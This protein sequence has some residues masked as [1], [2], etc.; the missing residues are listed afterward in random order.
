MKNNYKS[1]K[2]IR[3]GM[4]AQ[5]PDIQSILSRLS[6]V[7]QNGNG[8]TACCPAHDDRN[9]S[10]SISLSEDGSRILLHCFAGCP[11]DAIL[12]SLGL[13]KSDLYAKEV[14][15]LKKSNAT[16]YKYFDEDGKLLYSKTR[17]DLDDGSK[18]FTFQKPDGSYG[19]AGLKRV[20]YNLPAVLG[21]ETVYFTEGEKCADA[22]NNQGYVATTLDS[23][24][25]SKWLPSYTEYFSGKKVI[26]LPDIDDPG[27]V[28]AMKIK[29]QLPHAV[30]KELPGLEQK[31]DVAD[32]LA[33]GHSMSEIATL[34][35]VSYD[36]SSDLGLSTEGTDQSSTLLTLV[37]QKGV[38]LFRDENNILYAEINQGQHR[39]IVPMDGELF[40]SHLQY[41]FFNEMRKPIVKTRLDAAMGV[42]LARARYGDKRATLYNRVA[43]MQGDFCYDLTDDSGSAVL[44][45]AEGWHVTEAPPLLFRRYQHQ[46]PQVL[47]KSGGSITRIFDHINV[48]EYRLLFLC[49]LVACYIP[50]IPHPMPII[51]GE[52]GAAKSTACQLLK[53]LIDPSSLDTL[54]L[55]KDQRDLLVN[56]QQHY[57]LPFDNVSSIG[58]DI[59]D[60][61]CRAITGGAIQQRRLHSNGEDYIFKFQRCLALNGINNVANRADLLDR[62]ILLELERVPEEKRRELREVYDAF[63]LDRPY[64]LGAIFD[65]LSAAMKIY[66]SVKLERLPRMADFCRWGYAIAEALEFSGERFLEEYRAIRAEQDNEAINADSVATLIVE[67]MRCRDSWTGRVSDL[68]KELQVVASTIGM[69][70]KGSGFPQAAN[71]LS[72]RLNSVKSNLEAKGI[73]YSRDHGKSDGTYILLNNKNL[74]PLSSIS[75]N[76]TKSLG[77]TNGDVGSSD[78]ALPPIITNDLWSHGDNGD[79]G[80]DFE[81]VIF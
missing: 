23:G 64:L 35:N 7:N 62:S 34:P 12:H 72:R 71:A 55:S 80:D 60:T 16:S 50:D 19:V 81:T 25:K 31:G 47:P 8:Y 74:S 32:W 57:F 51:F 4:A 1:P 79:N 22:V 24:A 48:S 2:T 5:P 10:L 75:I 26:I 54:A 69:S 28:Y 41:L 76:P 13:K 42:L 6:K 68:L 30:I 17:I 37:E 3:R 40:R 44:V 43:P 58:A 52:K 45:A 33:A 66:P 29:A 70:T 21:A 61:L 65:A 67:Y 11:E 15:V 9:P 59:S 39:Q 20:P 36:A 27:K 18:K 38:C 53:K 73:Q 77:L 63:E 56:C 78:N 14:Q 49:W 46:Q